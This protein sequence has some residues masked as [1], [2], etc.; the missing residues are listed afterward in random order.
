MLHLLENIHDHGIEGR[1]NISEFDGVLVNDIQQYS[2]I[3]NTDRSF[4]Q[5]ICWICS[6]ELVA[7]VVLQI[8]LYYNIIVVWVIILLILSL[9]F[10]VQL[11]QWINL[12]HINI[13]FLCKIGDSAVLSKSI[14][15][16]SFLCCLNILYILLH[17][18]FVS[19]YCLSII[20]VEF[21]YKII[22]F[23][24]VTFLHCVISPVFEYSEQL[25][26]DHFEN[27]IMQQIPPV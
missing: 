10:L 18:I 12:L 3:R 17:H 15:K 25:L 5:A 4:I 26:Y 16:I 8:T 24:S 27:I 7:M 22:V 6:F 11:A 2:R 9:L 20:L 13:A 19:L 21:Q 23:G 14:K 1:P